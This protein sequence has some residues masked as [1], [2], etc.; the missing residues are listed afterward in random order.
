MTW[1]LQP[2]VFSPVPPLAL[3]AGIAGIFRAR[4]AGQE[5]VRRELCRRYDAS[6]ALL[7]DSGTSALVIALRA[8]VR[9][10]GMIAFP[11]YACIDLTA[12]ALRAGV[13]VRLYDLDPMT[14]S[15]DLES[16]RG[17][18]NR[19]V[20]AIL[21][22]HMY[23]YPADV[24]AVQELAKAA[25]IPVIEDAAQAAGG[26]LRGKA[27]GSLS[28]I[29]I[30]SFGRGKG[31]TAG[32]GGALLAR[33]PATAMWLD[34]AKKDLRIGARGGSEIGKLTAQWLFARSL[35]YRIPASIPSLQ[36]GEM[37]YKPAVE[38]RSISA[39]AAAIFPSALRV[40]DGE[41]DY[42]RAR[43]RELISMIDETRK[44]LPIRPVAGSEPGF[45]RLAVLNGAVDDIASIEAFGAQRGYPLTLEQHHQLLPI[46]AS[47]ERAGRG[48]EFLRDR[49]FT[50]PTHSRV[51]DSDVTHLHEW[52]AGGAEALRPQ[53]F[54]T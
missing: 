2:P 8:L 27:L 34:H 11:S 28:D 14:L 39:V 20:D 35:L 21:V 15:P 25:G 3:L 38:P 42:R 22:A 1:R 37:V 36:L 7:T 31:M 46:L 54:A 45:L 13:R 32:S 50:L 47:H 6:D 12:A 29:S 19:G 18:I 53:A 41:L 44:V 49:L 43:A 16:V 23:G 5:I 24:P 51:R 26:S 17:V 9:P 10:G 52:L 48:A 4:D 40:A 30:L 33:T